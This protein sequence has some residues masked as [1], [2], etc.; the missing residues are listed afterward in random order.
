V[1]RFAI[2][3][4]ESRGVHYRI[5]APTTDPVLEGHFVLR[6]GRGLFLEQWT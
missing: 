5:D 3:R 6:P 1:A 4:A 2:A